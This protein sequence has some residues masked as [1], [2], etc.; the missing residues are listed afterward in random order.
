MEIHI[1]LHHHYDDKL[2]TEIKSINTNVK[3]MANE[4]DNLTAEVTET[5]D[6]QQSAITL[7]NGLKTKLDEAIAN[8]DMSRVV[9]LRDDLD[10]SNA[11]LAA[12]ITANTPADNGGT[13]GTPPEGG[14]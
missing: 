6:L 7:L 5:K 9:A 3:T 2:F 8:N 14:L 4:L 1:H 12:A 11:S 10:A 13:G